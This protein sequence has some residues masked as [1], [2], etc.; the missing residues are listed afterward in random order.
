[1]LGNGIFCL[2]VLRWSAI[3]FVLCTGLGTSAFSQDR[4]FKSGFEPN[5]LLTLTNQFPGE[6]AKIASGQH[7][8]FGAEF[9]RASPGL[10]EVTV[11]RLD[12]RALIDCNLSE[13]DPNEG[14]IS[15]PMEGVSR[16]I[17]TLEV[18][19]GKHSKSWPFEA[20]DRPV[21]S[22][23]SPAPESELTLGTA[24][25]ISARLTDPRIAIDP[26][27]IKMDF[28][29]EPVGDAL[30]VTKIGANDFRL[31]FTPTSPLSPLG[32]SAE[33]TAM[34]INGIM[35]NEGF[36]F[37]IMAPKLYTT[38]IISPDNNAVV[39]EST[40]LLKIKILTSTSFVKSVKVDGEYARYTGLKSDFDHYEFAKNLRSGPNTLNVRVV[41]EDGTIRELTRVVTYDAAPLVSITSSADFSIFSA[42]A[43]AN[44]LGSARNLTGSVENPVTVTGAEA[45]GAEA[46]ER[47]TDTHTSG[48]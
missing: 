4:I 33:L 11:M 15:C 27:S 10:A 39:Q 31:T 34:T 19:Y 37:E 32:H 45:R 44:A 42:V 14:R 40:L 2:R 25:T 22:E 13:A 43:T 24:V 46:R 3:V 36:S 41:F 35:A 38:E 8:T 23:L 9:V 26:Q 1:M 21:F 17:H 7:S 30:I 28:D 20:V 5:S 6:N 48:I 16:G 47:S 12:G 29:L 18:T